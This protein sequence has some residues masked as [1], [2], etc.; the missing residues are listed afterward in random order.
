MLYL[1]KL[2]I[3][4]VFLLS[5]QN[6]SAQCP[7]V[8]DQ[9]YLNYTN[10]VIDP[11][12]RQTFVPSVPGEL[13]QITVRASG[14]VS[15]TYTLSVY[16]GNGIGGTLLYSGPHTFSVTGATPTIDFIIPCGQEPIISVGTTYTFRIQG[17]FDILYDNSG[18]YPLGN[19]SNSGGIPP[20]TDLYFETWVSS[21]SNPPVNISLVNPISCVGGSDGSLTATVTGG[22][23]PITYNWLPSGNTQTISGLSAN[24]YYVQTL[25]G[26]GCY[27]CVD[28]FVLAD[29]PPIT[30][31]AGAD[32]TICSG[33]SYVIPT[34]QTNATSFSWSPGT[35]LSSV[36]ALNPTAAPSFTTTYNVTAM[37]GNGCTASDAITINVDPAPTVNAGPDE[38]VC[39]SSPVVTLAGS[40]GNSGGLNWTSSGT[41][42]F[43]SPTAGNTTYT[44]SALDISN[45]S[46]VLTLSNTG[47]GV[48]GTVSDDM[49]LTIQPQ[50]TADAGPN[51]QICQG[52]TVF[53]SGTY[54][55][56]SGSNWTTSGTGFFADPLSTNTFYV[57]SAADNTTGSVTLTLETIGNG[58]CPAGSDDMIVTINS[59]PNVTFTQLPDMCVNHPPYNLIEGA[60]SGGT[61]A[62]PGVVGS[63]F[64]PDSVGVGTYTLT[65]TYTD[66]NTCTNSANQ[67]VI[68]HG[69]PTVIASAD[70]V[71][72]EGIPVI[73][74][75][76]G[77]DTYSWDNGANDGVSFTPPV[78][79][80]I[81]IVTGT[82]A[83]GCE[84]TDTTSVIVNPNPGLSVSPDQVFCL[85][86]TVVLTASGASSYNWDSGASSNATY[87]F[88][89]AQSGTSTVVGY[90]S[91]GCSSSED[92]NYTLDDP[93][94]VDAGSD[95]TICFGF[96]ANLSASG[97]VDYLWNGPDIMNENTQDISFTVDTSGY[98]KVTVTTNQGC[99]YSDSVYI[100]ASTDPSCTIEMVTSITP[101]DDGVNDTWRILGIEAF[102]ENTVTILNR[103]GDIVFQEE[104]YDN[105]VVVWDGMLNGKKLGA[106][107]YFYVIEI[108]NGPKESGWIQLM[109]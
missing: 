36:T 101:N 48:C 20:T 90:S 99:V 100:T 71:I 39:S 91:A 85:G 25:D 59:A 10:G 63:A 73:L 81:Y 67:T 75:G 94:L 32:A 9:S 70:Q 57:P 27:S 61:Y 1:K 86:D 107:T 51:A 41:G 21:M 52:D 4:T 49:I 88:F 77:A 18:L 54:T 37:N 76:S 30:V 43:S 19:Y 97:G 46:V 83:N 29:P 98:Y 62:G 66:G 65:Y 58:V 79:T 35:G 50:P 16:E 44:P 60:P 55:D 82:D 95:Q 15:G 103:W 12:H 96:T 72:C 84:N 109:K 56:A 69:L 93:T 92:I 33:G 14:G 47:I 108:V 40:F 7:S 23:G 89:P 6:I 64:H 34:T 28:T 2:L 8:S 106:G 42:S 26:A 68:V 74:S 104:G 31:N 45:G 3:L 38:T 24:T 87:E 17:G 102:P 78:G 80:N 105:D 13:V 53:L 5:Y 22:T 11:D